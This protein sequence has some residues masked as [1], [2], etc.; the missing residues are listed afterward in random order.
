MWPIFTASVTF[1]C[2]WMECP[3]RLLLCL[4]P[5]ASVCSHGATDSVSNAD[6][7][8]SLCPVNCL[9]IYLLSAVRWP[10]VSL[11]YPSV[12]CC[13][14]RHVPGQLFSKDT[15][16]HKQWLGELYVLNTQACRN[17]GTQTGLTCGAYLSDRQP[18]SRWEKGIPSSAWPLSCTCAQHLLS[19]HPHCDVQ[20]C[21]DLAGY[22]ARAHG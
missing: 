15:C 21:S 7:K 22:A 2:V 6:G 13:L 9:P 10:S 12:S 4:Y 8:T 20:Y 17:T 18:W 19:K 11:P 3:E 1:N 5:A 16:S 14:K